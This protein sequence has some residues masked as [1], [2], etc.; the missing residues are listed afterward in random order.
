[1]YTQDCERFLYEHC[2]KLDITLITISHRASLWKHHQKVLRFVSKGGKS[3]GGSAS[4]SAA[5][6]GVASAATHYTYTFDDITEHT[7]PFGS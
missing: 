1:M 3:Q 6:D 4:G 5:D 7:E 2:K